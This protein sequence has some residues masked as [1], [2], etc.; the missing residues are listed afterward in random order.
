MSL[1]LV[2]MPERVLGLYSTTVLTD[3]ARVLG[4]SCAYAHAAWGARLTPTRIEGSPE[5]PGPRSRPANRPLNHP[6]KRTQT[7]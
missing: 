6:S 7:M 5:H 3:G 2:T 4:F 1:W